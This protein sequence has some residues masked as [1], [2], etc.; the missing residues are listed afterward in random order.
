MLDVNTPNDGWYKALADILHALGDHQSAFQILSALWSRQP[1]CPPSSYGQT[2]SLAILCVRTAQT[3]GQVEKVRDIIEKAINQFPAIDGVPEEKSWTKFIFDAQSAHYW[4]QIG[5]ETNRSEQFADLVEAYVDDSNSDIRQ[6]FT[7]RSPSLKL[8]TT[9]YRYLY[10]ALL[11]FNADSNNFMPD[12]E[13]AG[14]DVDKIT[15]QFL[16]QQPAF[17]DQQPATRQSSPLSEI[18]C[19]PA[20]LEWCIHMLE[21]GRLEVLNTSCRREY[22]LSCM[23]WCAWIQIQ[24]Q[25][26]GGPNWSKVSM[27]Q[28]DMSASELLVTVVCMIMAT[29]PD[30]HHAQS[31]PASDIIRDALGRARALAASSQRDILDRF[32]HQIR[33]TSEQRMSTTQTTMDLSE[34]LPIRTVIDSRL[35]FIHLPEVA[36]GTVIYPLT[37]ADPEGARDAGLSEF[38]PTSGYGIHYPL[39]DPF[40]HQFG[41][42]GEEQVHW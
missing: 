16:D 26:T 39:V 40:L 22:N 7:P 24:I 8:D 37:L 42:S 15:R 25:G 30:R 14:L 32:L 13:D 38:R 18:P 20:C 31:G 1:E 19:L 33:E 23:L 6:H 5:D 2:L 34:F 36:N 17:L 3:Q 28:L 35:A 12:E 4:G 29:T 11:Y 41:Q 27:A 9:A 10:H 21:N